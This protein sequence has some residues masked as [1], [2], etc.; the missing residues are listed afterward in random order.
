MPGAL[1]AGAV[2]HYPVPPSPLDA[3]GPV[4]GLRSPGIW[5]LRSPHD[6]PDRI[7]SGGSQ[8]RCLALIQVRTGIQRFATTGRR[9]PPRGDTPLTSPADGYINYIH[10]VTM[11]TAPSE[12]CRQDSNRLLTMRWGVEKRLE[13]IEFRLFWE[14]GIN[15]ADIIE[16]F[17]VSVPQASKDLTLY[18]EK[19][20][21]NLV[22]DKS[23]KRYRAAMNFKP[24]FMEPKSDTY[25]AQLQSA[26]N[27]KD[28]SSDIWLAMPPRFDGMPIP[29]RRV[30]VAVLR[31]ILAAIR[32]NRSIQ[33]R[34][35][36]M[37]E[38]RPTPEWRRISPHALG[39][40]GLRWHIRAY[41]HEDRKF[42]DFIFS[43]CL[44]ARDPQDPGAEPDDDRLWHKC[45][46]VSLAPNPVL[47]K[48]QREII[49]QDYGMRNGRAEIAVRMA[50]L[51]Y[52]QKRLRLDTSDE[53]GNPHEK[54]VVV[55]NHKEFDAALAEA[56]E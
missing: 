11:L 23:A 24:V 51:Y 50:L 1:P 12:E 10:I 47:S 25:L 14:G 4:L 26:T 29:H 7:R 40:D 43:R 45:F 15:R 38:K 34:Y 20:S 5:G 49:A 22:Y 42:K 39:N 30:D 52:F 3:G 18:E 31:A 36:S 17:G 35:Q 16:H 2:C 55:A 41:C 13:F 19:A 21:G 32:E 53:P 37:N 56:M 27:P 44:N 28:G 48:S 6:R 46:A 8:V 9:T 33:I 54:P